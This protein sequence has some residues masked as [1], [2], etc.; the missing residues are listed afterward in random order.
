MHAVDVMFVFPC[1]LS[2]LIRIAQ[3]LGILELIRTFLYFTTD[4]HDCVLD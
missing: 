4:F 3:T 2:T 1:F